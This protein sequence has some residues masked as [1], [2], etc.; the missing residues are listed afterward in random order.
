MVSYLDLVMLCYYSIKV[1]MGLCSS[2]ERKN[3]HHYGHTEHARQHYLPEEEGRRN[4]CV[5]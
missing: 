1:S 4:Q 5:D 3:H 2:E